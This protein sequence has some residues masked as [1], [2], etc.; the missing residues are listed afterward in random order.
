M[1][2]RSKPGIIW[3]KR[4]RVLVTKIINF[5]II[6]NSCILGKIDNGILNHGPK[7]PPNTISDRHSNTGNVL[8]ACFWTGKYLYNT[9]CLSPIDSQSAVRMH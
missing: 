8:F 3:Q 1:I 2:S 7:I 6:L 4:F 5:L 9:V